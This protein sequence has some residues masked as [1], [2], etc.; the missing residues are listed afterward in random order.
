MPPN[1]GT[2]GSR[3]RGALRAALALVV[4]AVLVLGSLFVF[5][6]L[7]F[8]AAQWVLRLDEPA[9]AILG[10][11]GS[12]AVLVLAYWAFV[13]YYEHRRATELSFEPR[14]VALGAASGILLISLTL[15]PLFAL[16]YYQVVAFQGYRGV[17][18][19]AATIVAAAMLEEIVFRGLLFRIVEGQVGTLPS[20]AVVSALFGAV[21][22]A[23]D[24]ATAITAVSVTLLG[25]FWCGLYALSRSLW[26][27]GA[28][29]AAWNFTIF[30]A[31]I[32]LSG[33]GEWRL[34]SPLASE[35]HGPT[36]LTGGEFGPEDSVISIV[37]VA[38]ATA[39]LLARLRRPR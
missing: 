11:M 19:V 33:Q 5:K 29:H 2:K 39:W 34:L 7:A 20:L 28:H 26:V 12:L 32:S 13:R 1:A 18:V 17:P 4:G 6:R 27:V 22:L 9:A 31:G 8:P 37:V 35:D 25:A 14:W 15:L 3:V 23:N 38:F 16:G 36:W 21:H 30:L 24:G 10:R